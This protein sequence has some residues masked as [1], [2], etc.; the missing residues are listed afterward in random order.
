MLATRLALKCTV[1]AP[2]PRQAAMK[3][4]G[5]CCARRG[6]LQVPRMS[7]SSHS[8][9]SGGPGSR[10]NR[11]LLCCRKH[12]NTEI[13]RRLSSGVDSARLRGD[14]QSD[15]RETLAPGRLA[16]GVAGVGGLHSPEDFAP[17][18]RA[19]VMESNRLREAVRSGK[20]ILPLPILRAVDA[21]SN[22]V[23]SVI[24]AADFIRNAHADERFRDAADEAFSILAE[25]IQELNADDCLYHALCRVAADRAAMEGFTEEQRR[26]VKLHMAEFE[27]GGI[28]LSGEDRAEV[29]ELQNEATKL[30]RL[31]EYNIVAKRAAFQ[32][33]RK[34][35]QGVPD[36]LLARI[37]Q[38]DQQPSHRFTLLTDQ[39]VMADVLKNA[40]SGSLRRAMYLAGNSVA[41]ENVEV[42]ERLMMVRHKLAQKVGFESHAHRATSDK[43]AET[44]QEVLRFLDAL[45]DGAREKA[46]READMLR[47]A[48]MELE[49]T[50]ELFAWD[51][52]Y[53]MG[54]IKSREC[55]LDGKSLSEYFTLGGCLGGLRMVCSGLF[56]ISLEQVP[57]E[58]GEN[59]AAGEAGAG[60]DGGVRKLILRHDVEGVLGTIYLDLH[61]RE[62]KFGHAAHF[63]VRCGCAITQED[64]DAGGG[65][66]VEYQLPTVVLVCNFSLP[67]PPRHR[68]KARHQAVGVAGDSVKDEEHLDDSRLMSHSEVETLF[69]EFGHALHSLLSRTELQHVSGT[70]VP[71]DFCEI[72]SHLMEHFVWDRNVLT[73]F[74]RHH[75]TGDTPP[76]ALLDR[77]HKSKTLFAGMAIQTQLL[78]ATLDQRLFGPQ[79]DGGVWSSTSIADALQEQIAGLPR[80]K[81]VF[82][83]SRFGHFTGY[84]ASYYA[85]L[86]AKMFTSGIWERHFA[87]DPLNRGAG[88]LL[89]K[90]LLIHGGA[91][92][93][94]EILEALL[95][96]GGRRGEAG[97]RSGVA[98]LL[99]D[100]DVV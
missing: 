98:S 51:I 3:S 32:V 30:E 55:N 94:H 35:L 76:G 12:L 59:W 18:A 73:K 41:A 45:S 13:A 1:R 63:T 46:A 47:K 5:A 75:R 91:K 38:P 69:H 52:S 96:E 23:C 67:E 64:T 71:V 39:S 58:S 42:L 15:G 86:Y 53:Y 77:L 20:I 40:R 14:A 19:A 90:E 26:V 60:G 29:V 56:G 36:F 100:M 78:Y 50:S 25:Y 9:L 65:A 88:E 6:R 89:W 83:H 27:R 54:Y 87:A 70:R 80:C 79:P 57:I 31:F 92:D 33:D 24:D 17:L 49:G 82:W 37:P 81:G 95:G 10:V 21:I 85:Y 7:A 48:K 11:G 22:T 61:R 34:D 68:A 44:P 8:A 84:G 62:G 66:V 4:A 74:A 16:P 43:M 72:P 99:K 93:P 28:H 2:S 97:V